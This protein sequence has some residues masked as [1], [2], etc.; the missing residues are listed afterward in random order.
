MNWSS[1]LTTRSLLEEDWP[2]LDEQTRRL[3]AGEI[4]SYTVEKRCVRK[5]GALLWTQ[6]TCS[7]NRGDSGYL[8]AVIEDITERKLAE[9]GLQQTRERYISLFDRS[10]DCIYLHDLQ[11]HFLDANAA[12]LQLVGYTREELPTVSLSS[13]M[14][15][16]QTSAAMQLVGELTRLTAMDKPVEFNVKTKNGEDRRVEV[17][18][19][20]IL[21][22]GK[23]AAIQGIARDVTER[24]RI[25]EALRESEEKFRTLAENAQAA[26]GIVQGEQ[27]VY[28]NRFFAEVS[29][30]SVEE[31]LTMGFPQ[32]V[33]PSFRQTMIDR[34]RRR[35]LG[36]PEPCHYEFMMLTKRGEARWVDFC[37]AVIQYRGKPA[38]IGTGFDITERKRAEA[39]MRDSE[40]RLRLLS[41]TATRL[42][43]EERPEKALGDVFAAVADYMQAD[44]FINYL[45]TADGARLH[46]NTSPRPG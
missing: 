18:A 34:A 20:V 15:S 8:L 24:T 41:D 42:I 27:F 1:L 37:P 13:L 31:L 30:Y 9:D 6:L 29:G 14:D 21:H 7:L 11:G 12:A 25:Q 40:A 10:M 35:Q 46:L 28:A 44:I 32:L 19:A 3:W 17:K 45:L 38:I 4:N 22:D 43:G 26:I 36:E 33:H 16:N 5:D 23:P 2:V 39:A